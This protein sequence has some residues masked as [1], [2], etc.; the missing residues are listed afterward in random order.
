MARSHETSAQPGRPRDKTLDE[1]LIRVTLE[2]LS[3]TGLESVTMAKIGRRSGIPATS[4]YRR[5]PDA[6]SLILAAIKADLDETQ[7][8][9][10]DQGSLRAD[11]L[12]L[13]RVIAKALSPQRSRMLAGLLLPTQSDAT[14]EAMFKTKLDAFRSEGWRGAVRRA[15]QRGTLRPEAQE[16]QPLDD[17]AHTMIFFQSVVKRE[18][19]D[20]VFLGR[21]LDN[22][23]MPAL[24]PYRT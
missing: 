4:I 8:D 16:A 23:L 22:V 12:A 20:D 3:E 13:L 1:T 17:V 5:Y 18:P 14:L 2:V 24:E 7:F 6:R 9:L 19:A 15:V 11:L 21:L 10:E